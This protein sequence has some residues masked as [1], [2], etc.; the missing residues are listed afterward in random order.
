MR[1]PKAAYKICKSHNQFK[2]WNRH[3]KK[4]SDEVLVELISKMLQAPQEQD[5]HKWKFAGV[6]LNELCIRPWGKANYKALY[7]LRDQLSEVSKHCFSAQSYSLETAGI[8]ARVFNKKA[9]K[10]KIIHPY[11]YSD[12]ALKIQ[13]AWHNSRTTKS[14]EDYIAKNISKEERKALKEKSIL[15]LSPEERDAYRVSFIGEFIRIGNTLPQNGWYIFVLGGKVPVLY[16]G[17]K[18]KGFFHHTSFLGAEPVL[19]AGEFRV[20]DG[21]IVRILLRS[22]H[23]RPVMDHGDVLLEHLKKEELLGPYFTSF[24]EVEPYDN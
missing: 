13:E 2:C 11:S 24:L 19:S 4:L 10:H 12:V 21:K 23:Y 1:I 9:K 15:Y 5:D 20:E 3:V 22:G 8:A 18:Y 6:A 14:L 16:A 7:T 17:V